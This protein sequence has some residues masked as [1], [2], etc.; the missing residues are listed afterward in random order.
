MWFARTGPKFGDTATSAIEYRS[1]CICWNSPFTPSHADV[2]PLTPNER[3]RIQAHLEQLH[4]HRFMPAHWSVYRDTGGTYRLEIKWDSE[5]A[6]IT[7]REFILLFEKLFYFFCSAVYAEQFMDIQCSK[8]EYGHHLFPRSDVMEHVFENMVQAPGYCRSDEV[9]SSGAWVEHVVS[10]LIHT[11][12]LGNDT[13]LSWYSLVRVHIA[14]AHLFGEG[15]VR[16]LEQLRAKY[17]LVETIC[18]NPVQASPR[19]A[20]EFRERCRQLLG[21]IFNR[22]PRGPDPKS[23]ADELIAAHTGG[24]PAAYEH[25]MNNPLFVE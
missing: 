25:F 8:W 11:P 7:Q 9:R 5:R 2:F 4:F 15:A 3:T 24:G 17:E 18:T 16:N 14:R 20:N 13:D 23:V 1:D 6:R 10:L 12:Y 22:G 19:I 21:M